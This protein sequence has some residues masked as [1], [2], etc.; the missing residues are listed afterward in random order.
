MFFF[1][2]NL[3]LDTLP[4]H[5]TQHNISFE[6][7]VV[8]NTR[9]TP[10]QVQQGFDGILFFSPSAVVSFFSIN[11]ISDSIVLFAIGDTTADTIKTYTKNKII[12]RNSP[13]K[14]SMVEEAVDYF[15]TINQ[16]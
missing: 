4:N 16:S 1:T 8:Y 12:T 14:E 11:K 5:L 13:A 2:G 6:E 3:R 10:T 15:K 7:L 9:L